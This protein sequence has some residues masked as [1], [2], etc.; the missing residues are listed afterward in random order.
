MASKLVNR[1]CLF[2]C[3]IAFAGFAGIC[4]IKSAAAQD[5]ASSNQFVLDKSTEGD[6]IR[7]TDADI[8]FTGAK[9]V[10]TNGWTRRAL[11][12]LWLSDEA[13]QKQPGDLTAWA[14]VRFDLGDV[15][16]NDLSIFTENN[17]EQIAVYVNGVNIFKNYTND[18]TYM[19][20]WNHPYLI[21]VPVDLLQ[22]GVNEIVIHAAAGRQ[23]SIGIGT[24][25]LGEHNAVGGLYD[26]QYFFR[27]DAPKTVN[28]TMLLLSVLVF[29]MWLGRRQE[30]ELLWLALTGV[31]W[32]A[33]DYHF[34]ART[35]PIEPY[36]FQQMSYYSVYFAVAFGLA[37]CA[38][39]LKLQQRKPIILAM[40]AIGILLSALRLTLVITD[41]TDMISSLMTVFVLGLFLLIL[42]HHSWKSRSSESW[43]LLIILTMALLT[44]V[45]DIG[46]IPDINWWDGIGFHFQPYI[47]FV[48]FLVFMMSLARRF[49]SALSLVE[50]T[51]FHLE[52]SVAEATDALAASEKAR[53]T[54]EIDR[55]LEMERD[56]MMHEMHDGIGSNLVTALAVARK[57]NA[58][59]ST[60]TTLQRAIGDLKITVDSLAPIEGDVVTLLANLRHRM[61]REL[62]DAGVSSIW[63]VEDCEQLDW[64]DASH[65]LHLLRLLQEAISNV[66]QHASASSITLVCGPESKEGK[67]GIAISII[68]DGIGLKK[69][70]NSSSKGLDFM[71]QRAE[72][73]NGTLSI[74]NVAT[75]GTAVNLWI[76]QVLAL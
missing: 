49:L 45:H 17:R 68:D 14:R 12:S 15:S 7:F 58:P 20:G 56:R 61:E 51:N 36:F 5:P 34:F 38:E 76:P 6:V 46:R 41:R 27:I 13:R 22:P 73:L 11:P 52:Q 50:E 66:L 26:R 2:L 39:F 57:R 30:M 42:A 24:I 44:G 47:G 31:F 69:R 55:A 4:D 40:I 67:P 37:F 75:G 65:S 53:R 60:I 70:S 35:V 62:L 3:A 33:R 64:M 1:L 54:M 19:L 8:S 74:E 71:S 32:F 59:Q 48:L 43:M 21:P 63:K 28:W 23:H 29:I 18:Q 10:P 9:D 16:P 25:S 72:T